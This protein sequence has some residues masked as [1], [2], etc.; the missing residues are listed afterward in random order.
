MPNASVSQRLREQYQ[1]DA[2]PGASK[3]ECPFCHHHAFSIKRDDSLAKCFHGSCGRFITVNGVGTDTITLSSVLADI[4][5]DFH[6]EL[7]R[8]KNVTYPDNAYRYLVDDRKIHPRVVEDA[9]LGAIPSGY[10]V[11]GKFSPLL[12]S[13]SAQATSHPPRQGR[14][15]T[16]ISG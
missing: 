4:Y 7:L 9:M 5:H 6:Q 3:L 2:R 10:D 8:L 15:R 12:D 11:N 13:L 16:V 14:Q 1:L